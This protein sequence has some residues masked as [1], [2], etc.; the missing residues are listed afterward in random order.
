M[1]RP[2]VK[3]LFINPIDSSKVVETC[4]PSLGLGYIASALRRKFNNIQFKVIEDNVVREIANWQPDIVGITSVSQYYNRAKMYAGIAK[5]FGLP[6]IIGGT[7][8]SALPD[9]L[10][11]NMDVAIIGE[12][13]DTIVDLMEVYYEYGRFPKPALSDIN[14]IAFKQDGELITT[15]PRQ[16]IEPLDDIDMPYRDMLKID[17]ATSMFSSRGCPYRCTFCFSSR[18]WQKVRFFSAEYVAYE[19]EVLYKKYGANRISFLDDLFIANKKRLANIIRILAANDLLGKISFICNVR[20]NLVDDEMASMLQ[21]LN[22]ELVGIGMESGCQPT[23][24]Y[25]KGRGN[26]TVEDH[27]R[28]IKMLRKYNINSHP[29]FIIGSP[30]EDR[31]AIMETIKFIKDNKITSFEAYVL[32]PFPGTPVW[33]YAES[34]GLVSNNMDWDRLGCDFSINPN[35]VILSEKL[36]YNEIAGFYKQLTDRR[37]MYIKLKWIKDAANLTV[38]NPLVVPAYIWKRIKHG[39]KHNE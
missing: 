37:D 11:N 3:F 22:T 14:G 25:L 26:I 10:T 17:R 12:G 38:R 34:R 13:E 33:D 24:E 28:A 21:S 31:E 18:Y 7:H 19:I 16:L 35:P 5:D 15:Q 4:F 23:L 8:I 27:I 36:S 30:Y 32:I 2:K 6:I 29:S 20:S 9:T 39:D 1:T